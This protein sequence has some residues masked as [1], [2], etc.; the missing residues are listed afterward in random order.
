MNRLFWRVLKLC[1]VL[2]STLSLL[3]SG[4]AF[5]QAA[6]GPPILVV[7]NDSYAAN[8]FGRYL[9]EILRAEGL[10][11]FDVVELGALT[12]TDLTNHDLA[13][14]AE[15]SL[16]SGQASLFTT[17]VN[18]GGR[19]IAMRPDSQIKALFSL[20]ASAGVLANGYLRI[21]TT[22]VLS[23]A[24]PGQG[25]SSETLQ[26]HGN[27]DQYSPAGGSVVLAQLYSNAS[28][29]TAYPAVIAGSSGRAV[30]F[31]Y[32]LASNVIYTR[33]G[34]PANASLDID[35][36]AVIRTIDL[37]Q[38][39]GGGAPWVNR[40]RIHIPQADEQQRLLARLVKQLV[41]EVRPL[42]QLWY[43]P[44]VAKTMLIL[45]ADAHGN[46]TSF[47]QTEINSLNARGAKATFYLALSAEPAQSQSGSNN[48]V[49]DWVA[50]GHAFGIH[51]YWNK[52][53]PYPPYNITNLAE[54]YNAYDLWFGLQYPNVPKSLTV[55]NHQIAWTGWTDA[56]EIAE[57]HGYRLDTDF[58]HWGGWL[59]KPDGSWP[60]G[61]ITGSGQPMKFMRADGR[62]INVYQQL[63]QLVD[64][65]LIRPPDYAFENLNAT[66]ALA[67]SRELIDRSLARDYAA[68]MTQ[69]H[70]D[71]YS[72]NA[73]AWAEGTVEYANSQGVPVWNADQWLTFTETR[74]DA[75][76]NNI[77]WDAVNGQLGFTLNA[78]NSGHTLSLLLPPAYGGRYF[79]SI[80]VDGSPASYASFTVSGQE[81]IRVSVGA[82]NH[83]FNIGYGAQAN[84]P[85]PTPPTPVA[86]ATLTPT[87]TGTPANTPTHTPTPLPGMAPAVTRTG[88]AAEG[89]ISVSVA[90]KF[91]LDF[92]G[93]NAWQPARWFDLADS[94]SQ[95]L[96]NKNGSG[97]GYNVLNQPV[98]MLYN[99]AWYSL[100]NAQEASVTI[101]E[102]SPA[103][104]VLRSQYHLRPSG[105]DFLVRTDYTVYA[106]GR[107]AVN[108]ALQNLSGASR[109]LGMIEYA[110]LNVED[111]LGWTITSLS[112]NHGLG[113]Q[114]ADGAI[115]RPNLLAV[116]HSADTA[117]DSDGAGNRYWY[118]T[119]QSLA[120]NASFTRQWELQLGPG[121][122][123][124]GDLTNRTDDARSPGLTIVSGATP[125]GTGFDPA[126]AAYRLLAGSAPLSFYPTAT[127][128]RH[129]PIFVID[130][131]SS[132]TW[133]VSLNG[134]VLSSSGQPQGGQAIAS[135]DSAAQ[136]LVIQY[137][138]TIPA[139]A[140]TAERTFGVDTGLPAT[141]TATSTATAIPTATDTP[142][143]GPTSTPTSTSTATS[144]PT[145]TA[146]AT[147]TPT[148]TPA[149]GSVTH[150][151]YADFGQSCAAVSNTFVSDIEGGG[152]MLA[153][154]FADDFGGATLD[155]GRWS[156]GSWSGGS[157]AP[158][159]ASSLV[160]LPGGGWVR[161]NNTYTHG[162]IEA[163]AEFG[164]GAWQHVGFGSD[165]FG[166]D[167]YFIFSTLA[168][169]GNLYARVNNTGS[170]QNLNLG[171]IPTGLH[172]YRIEWSAVDSATD[173]VAFYRDGLFQ[174]QFDLSSAGAAN[175]YLYL[176]NNGSA[177]LQVDSAQV[178]P[179]YVGSGSYTGCTLDAGAGYAWQ[180]LSW[181]AS[182]PAGGSLT[183][184]TRS[185][186]DGLTWGEWGTVSVSGGALAAPGR[187]GQYRLLLT[188]SDSQTSPQINSITLTYSPVASPTAT[189]TDTATLV[190]PTSTPTDT[191]TP[192]PPTPTDTATPASP[193]STPTDTATPI[194]PTPTPTDTATSIPP[195]S[196]PTDTAT[197]IPPTPT[198]TSTPTPTNTPL[199][200]LIFGD[201]FELGNLAAWSA[202]AIDGGDL[203]A[204]PA[205]ALVG[206]NGLRAVLDDNIAIYVTD[207]RPSAETRYRARFYFDPNTI[208]MTNGNA[209]YIFYGYAGTSTV[210]LR[211]EFR[212]SSSVYQLRT[213]LLNDGTSWTTSSWFTISDA[214]HSV[215]LAW[216]AS[217]AAGANNGS[218]TFWLDGLQRAT[219][220]G[221]D[222]DTRRVD[223][224][225]LGP[226][227]GIDN[228]T[229]G[230]Y[231][232][233]AF[234]S[235]RLNYI[236]PA[237]SGQSATGEAD[238]RGGHNTP[239]QKPA[240]IY[241]PIIRKNF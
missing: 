137:L 75:N 177:T 125:V 29:A 133:S 98:E 175:F 117:I 28:T 1:V 97:P 64:E 107:V 140:T 139:T 171:P 174:A 148:P 59:Q 71:Y 69:F 50:Q 16:T 160:T 65:Q 227:A 126:S 42:P 81:M 220:T 225:R 205:A 212:R 192:I 4:Q 7:V 200:D 136:R 181:N 96:A 165:G 24:I 25:L 233:D 222:N 153:A 197:P 207:D 58:Y 234:E 228:G 101:L 40:D 63:T 224:V 116:N 147:N 48:D 206:S 122:Q 235:R 187:Y 199:P 46:P 183:V 129:A 35:G 89:T 82:G 121:G 123:S 49:L 164:A 45:T 215:E 12:A 180:N 135:Y 15:T 111:A 87:S 169:D 109:T 2:I 62:L 38:G 176:S 18:N 229:R 184:E 51:P 157:Y 231:Y 33:Q 150:T 105:S 108:L 149:S 198:P 53:D 41:G 80:L 196:T 124:T 11:A 240:E 20:G 91:Q 132:S 131:W 151:N 31:T 214:P 155:S 130:N 190:P 61:Y 102:E 95:D 22:A 94:A 21:E 209:H 84:T 60:H 76:L 115:P 32:D 146:T 195:T 179:G 52:P 17:Y 23:G 39:S 158:T 6:S 55:R 178:T 236:G 119:N 86:T 92:T 159:L 217:T 68:L 118:V 110:F 70:V 128:P 13:I 103:R 161:S 193:T 186:E 47:Y 185:S 203:S 208:S 189:P 30:A 27:A 201:G 113:F 43:F 67:V 37:F 99:G 138:G 219:L 238:P 188:T 170:E 172:R 156:S 34:N 216:Q 44:G 226:V 66:Q 143:A 173:R 36:D 26:I 106:S 241:L 166:G 211:V 93:A 232:F 134:T 163:T 57:A 8:R 88:S 218:L 237:V 230:T 223:R 127:Q 74:H 72:S 112:S 83:S 168:G 144:S 221:V 5:S 90:G 100:T 162:V 114:R 73:Q 204:G 78:A 10:N 9:G 182:L 54:G 191:A 210:V 152:V 202:S 194:P 213:G 85:T 77:A 79:N 3:W 56:A 239:G 104:L 167:K 141:P 14:L 145:N 154:A 142:T 120:A 19:L